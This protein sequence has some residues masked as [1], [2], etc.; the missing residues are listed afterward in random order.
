MSSVGFRGAAVSRS[1]GTDRLPCEFDIFGMCKTAIGE[2]FRLRVR[3]LRKLT[4]S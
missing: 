3:F 4:N 1:I 2:G